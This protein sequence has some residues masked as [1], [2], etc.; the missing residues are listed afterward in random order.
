MNLALIVSLNFNPGHVSHL[1]AFYR[2]L[3]E[4]GY[5]SVFC[6]DKKF[7]EFLP[8]NS[9]ICIYGKDDILNVTLAVITF[10]SQKNLFFIRRI[11]SQGAKVI[12]LFHEPLAPMKEY[13]RAGFSYGYLF[14]LWVIN[15]INGL[16]VKWSSVVLLPS[17]KAMELYKRN[18]LYDNLNYHYIPLLY[19]DERSNHL[20]RKERKYFS[21]IGTIA[22]DHSFAEFIEF[23]MWAIENNKFPNLSFLIATK[24][25]F[26]VPSR[27]ISS[28]R[29]LVLK[30]KPLNDQEINDCYASSLIVWNAYARTTQSGVLA[31]SFMFG[32]PV[33][34]LKRNLSEFTEDGQDVVAIDDNHSFAQIEGAISKILKNFTFF[35]SKARERFEND[36]FY[37]NYNS[38]MDK[39]L[40]K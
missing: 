40:S 10:P 24:S 19:D 11:K 17:K 18:P 8:K 28:R 6:V 39:I 20:A 37:K 35:S 30:G 5:E 13:R 29:V 3:N 36:F 2:Q 38:I 22:A 4:L 9:R 32:S 27:L 23:V 1:V 25:N 16:T 31:K 26:E 7:V 15:L 14:R 21:Y 33:I 12:Y 34:V